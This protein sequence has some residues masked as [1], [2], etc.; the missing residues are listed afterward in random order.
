MK[1]Y[2]WQSGLHLQPEDRAEDE[3]LILLVDK[4][5]LARVDHKIPTGPV[6]AN[7]GNKDSIVGMHKLS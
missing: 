6:Q 1:V 4:L 3:A 5:K 2:W 7:L